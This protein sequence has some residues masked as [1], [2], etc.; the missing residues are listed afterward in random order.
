M[1][2]A[3]REKVIDNVLKN[4]GLTDDKSLT[5][6]DIRSAIAKLIVL[7]DD[8]LDSKLAKSFDYHIRNY[9]NR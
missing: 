8:G 5:A 7:N 9:H 1:H 2:D 6:K 4:A 3:Q